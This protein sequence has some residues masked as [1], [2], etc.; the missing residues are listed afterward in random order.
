[1]GPVWGVVGGMWQEV[2]P[3]IAGDVI[4]DVTGVGEWGAC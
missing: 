2:V 4:S 3:D 1:M